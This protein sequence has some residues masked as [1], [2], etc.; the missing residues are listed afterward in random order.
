M[1]QFYNY[2]CM[3]ELRGKKI[4]FSASFFELG[5]RRDA[6]EEQMLN[7]NF[8]GEVP[9]E[10]RFYSS[11]SL[12]IDLKFSPIC[13]E[14]IYLQSLPLVELQNFATQLFQEAA[15]ISVFLARRNSR[16]KWKFEILP[17]EYSGDILEE[18]IGANS[19]E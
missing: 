16:A 17:A 10:T 11:I 19:S 12:A 13:S 15:K 6:V 5:N 4:E 9:M 7:I 1:G 2:L 18:L 14:R 8:A 3:D